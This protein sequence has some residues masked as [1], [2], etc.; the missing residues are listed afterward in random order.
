MS[1]VGV[2]VELDGVRREFRPGD[3]LAGRYQVTGVES[4]HLKAVE[5]SVHWFTDGKGDKDVGI[6][7]HEKRDADDPNPLTEGTFAVVL[8]SSPLSYDGLLFRIVW[9]VRVRATRGGWGKAPAGV[10][11]FLLGDVAQAFE[12]SL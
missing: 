11:Y 8:P 9:C 1:D 10:A 12:A 6:H 4:S 3:R 7:F 2:I 5:V